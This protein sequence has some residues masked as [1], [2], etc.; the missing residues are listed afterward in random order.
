MPTAEEIIN[1]LGLEPLLPE[2]GFF[3]E[4]Y[5]QASPDQHGKPLATAIYYLL[6][7]DS[8]SQ[9]HR[10]PHDELWHVYLGDTVDMLN[11]HPDGRLTPVVLGPDILQGESV[12][13]LVP[14]QTW[15]ASRL[16]PGGRFALLGT[17]MTPG[18]DPSDYEAGS[19]D[20]LAHDYPSF[21]DQIM[22]FLR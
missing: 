8:Q 13:W 10:L 9:W 22:R 11:L 12:Q 7:P 18:F 16:K 6:T 5:R 4:T 15:Q 21:A 3:R 17:T 1:H 14:A 2:G 20:T 19:A